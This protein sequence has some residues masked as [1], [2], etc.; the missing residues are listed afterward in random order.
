MIGINIVQALKREEKEGWDDWQI[1][2]AA[3]ITLCAL[4]VSWYVRFNPKSYSTS[5]FYIMPVHVIKD[6]SVSIDTQKTLSL[7]SAYIIVHLSESLSL[8]D[9]IPNSNWLLNYTLFKGLY[10][11]FILRWTLF[12]MIGCFFTS[13]SNIF[14]NWGIKGHQ[15]SCVIESHEY[16]NIIKG[17]NLC[18]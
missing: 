4:L 9:L 13:V 8:A 17:Q 6:N 12:L 2:I 3:S 18:S 11:N 7:L 15:Y 5:E 10:M 16:K 14:L 1:P